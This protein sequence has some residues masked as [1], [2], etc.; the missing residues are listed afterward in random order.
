MRRRGM[1]HVRYSKELG[2][3]KIIFKMKNTVNEINSRLEQ[4]ISDLEDIAIEC[5]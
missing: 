5:I 4:N 1:E 2:E 3:V